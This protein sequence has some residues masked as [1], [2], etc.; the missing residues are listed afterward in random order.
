[1]PV[2]NTENTH[3]LFEWMLEHKGDVNHPVP[4]S[5]MMKE[6]W[7]NEEKPV[8]VHVL[9]KRMKRALCKPVEVLSHAF[10]MNQIIQ[11][12][13]LLGIPVSED[14]RNEI[15]KH[16]TLQLGATKKI[17]Q[18]YHSNDGSFI[19]TGHGWQEVPGSSNA[20]FDDSST[21]SDGLTIKDEYKLDMSYIPQDDLPH[22]S[23]GGPF[24]SFPNLSAKQEG[25]LPPGH[26]SSLE[27]MSQLHNLILVL[28]NS[29][30]DS[31]DVQIVVEKNNPDRLYSV[32]AME[33]FLTS[34]KQCL[35]VLRG[36]AHVFHT[37]KGHAMQ[38]ELFM[39]LF[40]FFL[41]NIGA[42]EN[43]PAVVEVGQEI[44]KCKNAPS[45]VFIE[46]RKV[47]CVL[48]SLFHTATPMNNI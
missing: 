20:N 32:V 22:S 41:L 10:T 4:L 21:I 3:K 8:D 45:M 42:P 29:S 28:K 48:M 24:Q 33:E 11:L 46:V 6:F 36:G 23:E 18:A 7:A 1:M 17:I 25:I 38:Y 9:R 47:E 12:H 44:E 30:L 16:G 14:L 39:N 15:E 13:F 5:V 43:D 27:V 26:I 34:V 35:G 19:R 31:V 2:T 40:K 37:S